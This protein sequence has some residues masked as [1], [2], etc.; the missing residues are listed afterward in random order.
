MASVSS[1]Y[2]SELL[3]PSIELFIKIIKVDKVFVMK[4]LSLKR[5]YLFKIRWTI[6]LTTLI[7]FNHIYSYYIIFIYI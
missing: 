5:R 1:L 3:L 2:L 4:I 6:F 7:I